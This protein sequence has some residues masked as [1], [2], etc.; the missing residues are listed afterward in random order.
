MAMTRCKD[1]K[2]EM[3][4]KA[5]A[6]PKCGRKRVKFW[7]TTTYW[8]MGLFVFYVAFQVVSLHTGQ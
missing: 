8:G 6:C 2:T 7:I 1:C 3:S 4:T 5:D